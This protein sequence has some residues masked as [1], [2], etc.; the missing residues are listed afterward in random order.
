MKK[1]IEQQWNNSL[2]RPIT[3]Y[4]IPA[5]ILFVTLLI[6]IRYGAVSISGYDLLHFNLSDIQQA[7][8]LKI[9]IPRAIGAMLIGG[10]LA[11]SGAGLQGL[12]RN[13]LVDAGI[14]GVTT[15][16]SFAA[17]CIIS[18]SALLPVFWRELFGIYLLP[19]FAFIGSL[20]VCFAVYLFGKQ[21][22]TT[23]IALLILA[24]IALNAIL[25][26]LTGLVIYFS[27]DTAL[28]SFTFWSMGELGGLNWNKLFIIAPIASI[29]FL[30]FFKNTRILDVLSLGENEAF[31]LG[32]N[33]QRKN[34]EIILFSALAV[35]AAV[36]FCGAIGFVGLV[37][38]H[39]VRTAFGSSHQRVI[40]L[41]IL[42]GALLLLWAD[43]LA[44]TVVQPAELPIGII[45][46]VIGG[47]FFMFL[48]IQYK[49]K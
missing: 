43:L 36:A 38:P 3:R 24:G 25:G 29:T 16:A 19:F 46:S 40:P 49:R 35:G 6:Y 30:Y 23:N 33:L 28:R 21:Y 27:D 5:V 17:V 11:I 20:L 9:R 4:G 13:P 22:G 18:L 44:R 37:V 31:H 8:L 41:S 39:I 7:V 14:I 10:M 42:L 32:V 45:T 48:L 47:P 26:A 2:Q 15:G 34:R 12:F 1:A